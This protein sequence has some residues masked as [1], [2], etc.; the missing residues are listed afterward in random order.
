MRRRIVQGHDRGVDLH[1]R[2]DLLGA[3]YTDAEIRRRL[4]GGELNRVRPGAYLAGT[5]PED[6]LARHLTLA[7]ATAA[8]L[9][10]DA[11]LSHVSAAV[12]HGL[13]VW[14]VPLGHVH[15]TRNRRRSGGR[16]ARSVHVHSAP[17]DA[18]DIVLVDG[19]AVTA[20]ART[21]VD[22]ARAVPFEQAVVVADAA[23]GTGLVDREQLAAAVDTAGRWP[24]APA[25]RRVVAF[26]RIG[27]Q[28]AGESLS[29]VAIARA[30]LPEPELQAVVRAAADGRFIGQVDFYWRAQ[31]T[32]GEFD[33]KIKYGRLLRP[34][35]E[36]GD[37][38]YQEKLREDDLRDEDLGVTRW[39]W[40]DLTDFR[41]TAARLRRRFRPG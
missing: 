19:L 23:L 12:V 4:R 7:R 26:A 35:Q 14:G 30:G 6:D 38:V 17:L 21:V 27:A 33:G 28:S 18:D 3:G 36:P 8:V 15:A 9:S 22:V 40:A 25:A 37:A 5:A 2:S 29:R 39:R 24:G 41:P 11:V 32:V 31:R 13:A 16:R 10:P 1:R 34:G 20:L